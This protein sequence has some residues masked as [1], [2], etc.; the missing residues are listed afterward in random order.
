MLAGILTVVSLSMN[1][2]YLGLQVQ[3]EDT[4]TTHGDDPAI[5]QT[6]YQAEPVA[7]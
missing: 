3:V 1:D 6:A 4:G 5:C 7:P 2:S